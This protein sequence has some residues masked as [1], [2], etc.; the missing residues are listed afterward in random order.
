[1][2]R[3]T[4]PQ[5]GRDLARAIFA[6]P[7]LTAALTT[8]IV[9]TAVFSF[10]LHQLI[11]WAGFVAILGGLLVLSIVSLATQ[12]RMIGWNGLLPIS[13]MGF[14]GWAGVSIFWSQ[15]HWATLGGLA[16]LGVFA[17][18]GIYVALARDTIQV[19]RAFGDV[20]RF[21]LAVSLALE[22]FSGILIDTPI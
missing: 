17:V 10:A 11:G 12:W 18:L 5:S 13:L 16:Y 15:Y 9:G 2:A 20:L 14:V 3:Q 4:P 6:S 19:V 21:A 7:R 1:M 22:V 8:T